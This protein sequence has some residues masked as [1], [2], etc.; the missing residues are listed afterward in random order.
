VR[1]LQRSDGSLADDDENSL[2]A[3]VG[4]SY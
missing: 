1:C 4:K 3:V 2:V